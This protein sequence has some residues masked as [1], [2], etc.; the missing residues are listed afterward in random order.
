LLVSFILALRKRWS[1][2]PTNQ[3]VGIR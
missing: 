3:C 1:T 2:S